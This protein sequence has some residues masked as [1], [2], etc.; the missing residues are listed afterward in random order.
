MPEGIVEGNKTGDGTGEVQEFAWEA[1]L[2]QDLRGNPEIKGKFKTIG[3]LA[4]SHL[5]LIP[6]AKEAD[7]LKAKLG[8]SIPKLKSDAKPEEREAYFKAIG[9]PDKP[10]D[11]K[12]EGEN[13]H[14]GSV[15]WAQK[16]FHQVGLSTDQAKFIGTSFNTFLAE[17]QKANDEILKTQSIEAAAKLKKELGDKFDASVELARRV[18]KKYTDSELD[19][20]TAQATIGGNPIALDGRFIGFLI[21]MAKLTGE[22]S[23]S[24]GTPPQGAEKDPLKNFYPNSPG[25]FKPKE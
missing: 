9:R 4:K 1:Q 17:I 15:K 11:Y 25:M 6:K 14:E 10:E 5:D 13:L 24:P 8:D 16:T 3:D 22:D 20:F 12:F 19:A 18:W 21:K 7:G 23:S 2:P